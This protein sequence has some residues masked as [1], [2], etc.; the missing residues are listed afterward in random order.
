MI[1]IAL[2]KYLRLW[3]EFWKMRSIDLSNTTLT[4]KFQ[5]WQDLE[6]SS[7]IYLY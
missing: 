6:F 7:I 2:K 3:N 5:Q 4:R 1:A